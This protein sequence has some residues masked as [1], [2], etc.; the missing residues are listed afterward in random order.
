[1]KLIKYGLLLVVL[2]L[3]VFTISCS[4]SAAV[5]TQNDS[6]SV[7][8]IDQPWL[9]NKPV[10]VSIL[11][12]TIPEVIVSDS[13]TVENILAM[14][15]N[16]SYYETSSEVIAG[17]HPTLILAYPG[18]W[19][20]YEVLNDKYITIMADGSTKEYLIPQEEGL[21]LYNYLYKCLNDSQVTPT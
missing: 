2:P 12:D 3:L 6:S 8:V 17:G 13:T 9:E 14:V 10:A 21:A 20:R 1:M 4:N 5:Q 18:R 15:G 11:S 7:S 19:I 16:L